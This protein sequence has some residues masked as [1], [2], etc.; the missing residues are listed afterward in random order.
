MTM[1]ADHC[2]VYFASTQFKTIRNIQLG[3]KGWTRLSPSPHLWV[4]H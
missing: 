4:R 1:E 3:L 2:R